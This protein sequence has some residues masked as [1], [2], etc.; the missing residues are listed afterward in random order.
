MYEH[1]GESGSRRPARHVNPR[2]DAAWFAVAFL[3]GR[4]PQLATVDAMTDEWDGKPGLSCAGLRD[5]IVE[6]LKAD[7]RVAAVGPDD[8][9]LDPGIA[10]EMAEPVD[11]EFYI[12]VRT[13]Y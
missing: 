6:L 4:D 9:G 12:E 3:G 2:R 1:N 7:P 5:V 10:V 11:L 13:G 8:P